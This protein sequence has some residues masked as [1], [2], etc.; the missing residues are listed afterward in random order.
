MADKQLRYVIIGAGFSGLLCGI[1]LLEKG[2]RNF[3]IFEKA[4]R[5]GG[6]WR[7]NSYPGLTCDVESHVYSYSFELNP[8]WSRQFAPG[9]EIQAYI[10]RTADKYG[11]K[12]HIQFNNE[13]VACEHRDG[14]WQL[15]TG[16]GVRDTADVVIAATGV[17]HHP[18]EP[19]IP[20]M[21]RFQGIQ[22]H[23]ARWDHSVDLAGKRVAVVGTGSTGVQ[24]IGALAGN[25]TELYHFCRTP[26]WILPMR[27]P[28]IGEEEKLRLRNDGEALKAMYFSEEFQKGL[29]T[30][31]Y[32]VTHPESDAMKGLAAFAVKNLEKSVAD[33][34]LREKLRPD[35]AVGCKRLIR[36]E[37]YYQAIQHE[38]SHLVTGGIEAIEPEGIRTR[39]G[40][41]H[42]LDV[43][44][45][46]TGFHADQFLRPMNVVGRNG[47]S[48]NELW[49]AR[50]KA[51]L[52]VAVPEMPNFFLMNGPGGPVGNFS[53]IEIAELE[54]DY[55]QRLLEPV[56]AGRHRFVL[57]TWAA[58]DQFDEAR[59]EAAK[60]TIFAAGCD[61]WYLDDSGLPAVWP[62]TK[63]D[64]AEKMQNP[65]FEH[66]EYC[67]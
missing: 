13:V 48:L 59:R 43:I 60:H 26:Q 58:L 21:D 7:E 32:A 30:F 37:N 3:T 65:E 64:F 25:V 47:F 16:A 19:S 14:I 51:Y 29:E 1:K 22:F 10:E 52:S 38:R 36:S 56:E 27:N 54:W 44:V 45:F 49:E 39:D 2:N 6:T 11:V 53:L 57:P 15:E 4:D 31:N 40:K 61:S 5:V 24:I 17:L 18:N 55:F 41:L 62:W 9:P 50:P 8:N 46:A 42:Q 35:Y 66:Y 33:P 12:D 28:E 67:S 20:G 23:S 63:N 34:V